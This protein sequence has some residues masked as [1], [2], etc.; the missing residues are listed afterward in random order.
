VT[1][2]LRCKGCNWRF[3]KRSTG[4]LVLEAF[5]LC[6]N[7]S[8]DPTVHRKLFFSCPERHTP[9]EHASDVAA[10]VSRGRA[11]QTIASTTTS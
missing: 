4:L 5:V 2:E 7:C 10:F 9:I 3:G 6:R 8:T 1:A 11:R